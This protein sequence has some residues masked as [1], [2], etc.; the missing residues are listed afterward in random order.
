[1]RPICMGELLERS[2]A[3]LTGPPG[4]GIDP[5]VTPLAFTKPRCRRPGLA[6]KPSAVLLRLRNFAP[7]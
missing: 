7:S 1:M 4:A 2:L 3:I 5:A 6:G